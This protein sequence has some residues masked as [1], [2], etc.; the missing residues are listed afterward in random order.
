VPLAPILFAVVNGTKATP[1]LVA[2][3]SLG[4]HLIATDLM[5]GDR[6]PLLHVAICATSSLLAGLLLVWL[7]VRLYGREGILGNV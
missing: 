3:P 1:A 4:Q 2:I 5:R 6:I 7:A